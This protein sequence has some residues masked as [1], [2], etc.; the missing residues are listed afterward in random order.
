MAVTDLATGVTAIAAGYY[1]VCAIS[2]GGA[3]KCWGW[4]ACSSTGDGSN[5]SRPTP[6][7]VSNLGSGVTGIS[8]GAGH[9][10]ALLTLGGVKCWAQLLRSGRRCQY[11]QSDGTGQC[12]VA[13]HW[14]A[15]RRCWRQP[16]LRRPVGRGGGD[17]LGYNADGQ[18]G[19]GTTT[20]RTSATPVTGFDS[21]VAVVSTG[22]YRA[23]SR[24]RVVSGAG[25]ATAA[26][27]LGNNSTTDSSLPVAVVGLGA[28]VAA[29]SAGGYHTCALTSTGAMKCWGL[30]DSGQLGDNSTTTRLTPVDVSGLGSGVS[31]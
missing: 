22:A 13:H 18:I 19:D 4:N 31:A 9:S 8:V 3:V 7:A 23:R 20:N 16:F 10:C 29:I 25:A 14:R 6:V 5:S 26:V 28:G 30:N 12:F 21:G 24:R 2:T 11:V 27:R 1:H 17:V 15:G